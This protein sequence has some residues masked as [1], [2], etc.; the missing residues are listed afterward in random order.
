MP[1]NT[2]VKA[3]AADALSFPNWAPLNWFYKNIPGVPIVSLK[4][5]LETI[6]RLGLR[7]VQI[8]P[9]KNA[10]SN[11]YTIGGRTAT[12]YAFLY[13]DLSNDAIATAL[14]ALEDAL[15][16]RSEAEVSELIVASATAKDPLP[17]AV[18]AAAAP[19]PLSLESP[20]QFAIT[21]TTF[22]GLYHNAQPLLSKWS[23]TLT[24]PTVAGQLFWPTI[25][26]YGTAYNLLILKKMGTAE[27]ARRKTLLK[28]KWEPAWDAQ[29][30]NGL[31]YEIDL[32]IFNT[33]Q[34]QQADDGSTR[35]TPATITTLQQDPSTK[36]LTPVAV[37]VSGYQGAGMQ[38]YV[39]GE[40]AWLYAL[41]AVKTSITVW[42]TWLGHVYHWHIVTGAMQQA[43]SL[44]L[45]QNS[46]LYQLVAPQSDF[47]NAFDNVLL[48]LW[49]IAP[50]TSIT[51][52]LQFIALCDTFAAGRTFFDDDPY[53]TLKSLGLQQADF[54]VNTPWDQYPL[55]GNLLKIW[56]ATA[57]YVGA[58]IKASY[59]TDAAVANDQALQAWMAAAADPSAGNIRGL[60][61]MKT[62]DALASV[63]TSLLYRVTAHGVGRLP[64]SSNPG[65]TFIANFPPCLQNATVPAPGPS[66]S[67]KELLQ[68]LPNTGTLAAEL[69]FYNTFAF[70]VPYEPFIPLNGI[71][72]KLF[73]PGGPTDP[74]NQALVTYRQA[75]AAMIDDLSAPFAPQL[76]QWPLNVET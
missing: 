41:Q 45:D 49:R 12:G 13:G 72:S 47:L 39:P 26:N 54:T 1:D 36:A 48:L 31:F 65:L 29:V 55:V 44:N 46:A 71:D 74:R 6:G 8:L 38:T 16:G 70:S 40:G 42:G 61:A 35:F 20:E 60:P 34:P 33:L 28:D 23:A 53:T 58:F 43:M 51:S 56:D 69:A 75:I 62:R 18:R 50:P 64:A 2:A 63:L 32:S 24:D 5:L 21:W 3:S 67:T 10:L 66:I 37:T 19:A 9:A 14:D 68:Y 7:T 30:A 15:D 22:E 52:S 59:P 57:A 25:A 76:T 27:A 17:A 4:E 73:F 11:S